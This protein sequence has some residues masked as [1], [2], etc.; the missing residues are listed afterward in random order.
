[1]NPGR[2][3]ALR[4]LLRVE[5]GE[6]GDTALEAEAPAEGRDRALAWRLLSGTLQH[7]QEIDL[8]IGAGSKRSLASLDPVVLAILRLATFE[9][10]HSRAPA[11]AVVH[12]AVELSRLEASPKV[13][14]FVNA[15]LRN[16]HRAG[17]LPERAL[18]NHPEWLLRRWEQRYGTAAAA[19]WARS[20]NDPPPLCIA[21]G[22]DVEALEAALLEAGLEPQPAMAGGHQV[23]GLCRLVGPVGSVT[24]LPGFT[25]GQWWVQDA[26]AAAV[27]D[28]VGCRPGWRVLDACSAPGG[29]TFRLIA[30]GAEVVAV[31]RSPVRLA[32]LEQGLARLG[33]EAT[34]RAHDW[35]EG[36][37]TDLGSFDAILVDA[38][39]SG[40]GT[41][42]RHPEIRWRRQPRDLERNAVRQLGILRAIAPLLRPEGVLVYAVCSGEPEEG[43][44][45]AARFMELEPGFSRRGHFC[46]APP[47]HDE[48]AFWAVQLVTDRAK[49]QAPE[50]P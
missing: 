40:L 8:L 47:C 5:A 6:R 22:Q 16:Q 19:A 11:R 28:L 27:A 14:G 44:Q 25:E 24:E 42:R 33:M 30:Q 23:P 17:E 35:L 32:K 4:A 9:L 41:L 45:V 31:D 50:A 10:R 49:R 15:V 34:T 3:A 29:K 1:V 37:P 12:Q 13:S 18:L 43:E 26:A 39:C 36:T 7:R 21:S 38:P 46:S 20:N 2:R 48:D